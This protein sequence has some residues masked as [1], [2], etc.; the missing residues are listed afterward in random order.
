MQI[1]PLILSKTLAPNDEEKCTEAL[2][3]NLAI[4]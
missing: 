2:I 4:K 3:I 1:N